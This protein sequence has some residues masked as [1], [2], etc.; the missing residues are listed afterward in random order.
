MFER[1]GI[2]AGSGN[3]P[4]EIYKKEK[5]SFVVGLKGFCNPKKWAEDYIIHDIAKVGRIINS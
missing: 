2:I 3:L 1:L 4:L 5:Q